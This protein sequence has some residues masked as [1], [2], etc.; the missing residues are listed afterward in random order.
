MRKISSYAWEDTNGGDKPTKSSVESYACRAALSGHHMSESSNLPWSVSF[1]TLCQSE[2][3]NMQV[4]RNPA[5]L[6]PSRFS[7]GPNSWCQDKGKS[8]FS[9]RKPRTSNFDPDR[10]ELVMKK[11]L[12]FKFKCRKF[13]H[14]AIKC[15]EIIQVHEIAANSKNDQSS[16]KSWLRAVRSFS[17]LQ[18]CSTILLISSRLQST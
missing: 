10:K 6:N 12:Y 14:R 15:S 3:I 18:A 16:S 11:E 5:T 2:V 13:K 9:W 7:C 4:F 1:L 17:S 8:M